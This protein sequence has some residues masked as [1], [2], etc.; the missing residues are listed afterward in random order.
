MWMRSTPEGLNEATEVA[1]PAMTWVKK[2]DG[3]M[4]DG[5]PMAQKKKPCVSTRLL[6]KR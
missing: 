6:N 2:V 3:L 4:D 1:G 5:L